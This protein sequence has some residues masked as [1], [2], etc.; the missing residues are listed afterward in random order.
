M[1]LRHLR[2]TMIGPLAALGLWMSPSEAFDNFTLDTLGDTAAD[3]A[4]GRKAALPSIRVHRLNGGGDLRVDG[5]LD[6]TAWKTAESGRGFRVW[7]PDR[8]ANP[9]EET[10]FKVAYDD[11]AIYFGV[12][13]LERDAS[14]ISAKLSRRDSFENSDLVSIYL[15]PYL[16]HTTGYNFKVNPLG[17]V[18]DSYIYNDGDRDDN[19]DAVW[20]A[21]TYRDAQGWYAEIRIPFSAIRYK[22]GASM[23]WGFQI[24]RYMHGR[25]ED[26]AWVIWD[27]AAHGF[28]SHFGTLTGLAGIRPP[29][30]IELLP[31][32]VQRST[33][34]AIDPAIDGARDDLDGFQ[35]VG[36]DLKYGITAD[37]TLNATVQPDFGQVEADPAVLNLSP[38]ETFYE[39]KRPFFIEGNR[40]FEHPD[41]TLF[42]SRRIGTGDVNSRIR[43]AAKLT[44]KTLGGISVAALAASSDITGDGQ[45][46]N[47]FKNGN[48]LSRFVVGRF[49][50]EFAGGRHRFNLMQTAKL[51]TASRDQF[52]DFASR[53]AYTTGFD[54]DLNSKNREFN[55]QGSIVGSVINPERL[56]S[57]PSITGDP[58]YGTGGSLDIRRR[59]G[60]LQGGVNGRWEHDKLSIND[61]GFLS[62]PDEIAS[63]AYLYYPYNPEGKSKLLNRGELNLNA[64]KSWIYAGRT[65]LD[66]S[67][68]LPAWSYDPGHSQYSGLELNGWGQFRNYSAGWW[69]LSFNAEGTHRFET[70]GGPLIR[71]PLTYGGWIGGETDTRKDLNLKLDANHFRDTAKNHSTRATL[72]TRWN[73]S[74]AVNHRLSITFDNR[75]DDTQYLETVNLSQRPGGIGIGGLSYVYGDIHQRTVDLTLRSN[76]LFSRNQSLAIYAQPFLTVGD[77]RRA[78]E[79]TVPDSYDFETYLEPGYNVRD[80]DFSFASVNVNM[81][82]RWEYRPGS[83]FFLVWTQSRSRF[84][85]RDM[86]PSTSPSGFENGLGSGELFQNEPE[87]RIL[88]KVTYWIAI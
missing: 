74:S 12:A 71:E 69:G 32:V 56:A 18:L 17:V 20:E 36:A 47:L 51:N 64:W 11:G 54:F 1:W 80:F 22:T 87:N 38:F 43:Y 81:V 75:V 49:G 48:Q 66:A 5:R 35:N 6:D 55:V 31:Y 8:G 3:S 15:D 41:F 13:C 72:S 77:Y 7:D 63:S 28:V 2:V 42:Y 4:D 60:K 88:A 14:K 16:D 21:S 39:E 86:H 46:H 57:D 52:G 59:G 76:V 70:R 9:S 27:R 53:E 50:K 78:R 85:R 10:I 84:D 58:I 44:G 23:T 24:Y 34:P 37:L 45:A 26:T 83:T 82:Y 79:L 67:T 19:W 73:Q 68:G 61:L 29:R 25:G 30:Q 33:D 40:F 62:S 65:G